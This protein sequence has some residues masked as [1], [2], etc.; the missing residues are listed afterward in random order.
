MSKKAKV[1]LSVRFVEAEGTNLRFVI[2]V[3]VTDSKI[4][5]PPISVQRITGMGTP[6]TSKRLA[7][8][9]RSGK[10]WTTATSPPP[11]KDS[12]D[13]LTINL[14]GSPEH[15]VL[16]WRW[17]VFIEANVGTAFLRVVYGGQFK[18]VRLGARRLNTVAAHKV[19]LKVGQFPRLVVGL[20]QATVPNGPAPAHDPLLGQASDIGPL[21]KHIVSRLPTPKARG[22]HRP[23]ALDAAWDAQGAHPLPTQLPP[24]AKLA[25]AEEA[26]ARQVTEMLT[27]TAYGG[28][29][30]LYFGTEKRDSE[31]LADNIDG[32]NGKDVYGLIHA[33]QHL[34]AFGISSRGRP[35]HRFKSW[36]KLARRKGRR[37]VNAGSSSASL[38]HD[39]GGCWVI[40]GK[41]PKAVVPNAPGANGRVDPTQFQ[42]HDELKTA[43]V[44]YTIK[45]KF[46]GCEFGPGS[47]FVFANRKPKNNVDANGNGSF[48]TGTKENV[49]KHFKIVNV[50]KIGPGGVL[51]DNSAAAHAGFVLRTDPAVML[52]KKKL[53]DARFQLLDTGGLGVRGRGNGVTV[54]RV[55]SGFHT[56]NFDG[57]AAER[58]G[59]GDPFRGVGVWKKMTPADATALDKHVESVLKTRRPLGFARLFLFSRAKTSFSGF[60][61]LKI[62]TVKAPWMIYASPLVPMYEKDL[63]ANYA[64]VRYAWSLRGM[65][66]RDKVTA[67]WSI[68]APRQELAQAM[69]D[70]SRGDG[71]N[72]LA[73]AAYGKIKHPG[74]K[75]GVSKKRGGGID[76]SRLLQKFTVPLLDIQVSRGG[77]AEV[78]YKYSSK[79]KY[80]KLSGLHFAERLSW[81]NKTRLPMDREF[82]QANQK[83]VGFPAY[84]QP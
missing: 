76:V 61:V 4:K 66:A 69:I 26:W 42:C 50:W 73:N 82:L 71:I 3:R 7:V 23:D 25:N 17:Q 55:G 2:D 75:R 39:L 79:T 49:T 52:G 84:L 32:R 21:V 43:K 6:L 12:K 72:A 28:P 65:P 77:L 14:S 60:D 8:I 18:S 74:R 67:M 62:G 29:G 59:G 5:P 35:A 10:T 22:T 51:V 48:I 16:F 11:V 1:D 41:P 20:N 45:N 80:G 38:V 44:L 13:K 46:K 33:C 36:P 9:E 15:G 47:M 63:H 81:D 37:L 40:D 83:G 70:A 30:V 31:L 64:I 57:P 54:L 56:G 53:D 34:A 68:Y 58:I 78:T 19:V 24:K 27:L